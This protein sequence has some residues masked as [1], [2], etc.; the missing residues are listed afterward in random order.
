M[1]DIYV[2][3]T[4]SWIEAGQHYP[5]ITFSKLWDVYFQGLIRNNRLIAPREVFNEIVP[6]KGPEVYK[7]C[8]SNKRTF[9]NYSQELFPL[10]TE[11]LAQ[12]RALIQPNKRSA[13]AD[14]FVIA[15]ARLTK[16]NNITNS[17]VL[18]VTQ[19]NAAD[20]NKI[21]FVGRFYGIECIKL[22][23]LFQREGWKF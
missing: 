4:S 11:I 7:Y 5:Q 8:N 12:H 6:K 3:D 19:E 21:P 15:L 10:V 20:R 23:D 17:G 22:V 9:V 1:D 14:P 13:Q 2:F 18:I 16:S